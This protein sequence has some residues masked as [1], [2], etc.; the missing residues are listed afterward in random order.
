MSF[1][2]IARVCQGDTTVD[3]L[4][5]MKKMYQSVGIYNEFTE[6]VEVDGEDDLSKTKRK[7]IPD[8]ST[9]V[10]ATIQFFKMRLRQLRAG[11]FRCYVN[12]D[13]F[14]AR[15][16]SS[17]EF[18]ST[19]TPILQ[20]LDDRLRLLNARIVSKFDFNWAVPFAHV[21]GYVVPVVH[22][23]ASEDDGDMDVGM[24]LE[25]GAPAQD[26]NA[27]IQNF[28]GARH[29]LVHVD[30]GSGI[31]GPPRVPRRVARPQPAQ[32]PHRRRRG[33][34]DASEAEL[35]DDDHQDSRAPPRSRP[36]IVEDE[37]PASP[38]HGPGIIVS[39]IGTPRYITL[40]EQFLDEARV[41]SARSR[42]L[43]RQRDSGFFV[44]DS[45]LIDS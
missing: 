20:D 29:P 26:D 10:Q 28:A 7:Q 17:R 24:H 39:P 19:G 35:T 43:R 36:R 5:H 41:A 25:A 27:N 12:K 42:R 8:S 45:H 34:G 16:T 9:D 23:I 33:S 13:A 4:K 6:D 2:V 1:S 15:Q 11:V 44:S 14:K 21:L 30:H 31:A 38:V 32:L 3:K 18:A 40:E 37:I 22:P